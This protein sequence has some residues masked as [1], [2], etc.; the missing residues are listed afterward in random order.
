MNRKQ[1]LWA[2]LL[3][4]AVAIASCSSPDDEDAAPGPGP[5]DAELA[6]QVDVGPEGDGLEDLEDLEDPEVE[7]IE[8]EVLNANNLARVFIAANGNDSNAGNNAGSAVRSIDRAFSLVRPGGT[9]VFQAGTYPPLKIIG[10][11]GSSGAPIRLEASGSVEFRDSDYRSNAGIL[12][13]NSNH[14]EIV[15]MR[16]RHTLW[17]IYVENS[18]NMTIRGNDFGDIGQEG[19]R[20]KGGSSNIRID[21]NTVADTGRRTD[22]DWVNGEGCLLYTSDAADE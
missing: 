19:I 6:E 3:I 9:I 20:I 1:S 4:L 10:K 5:S 11:S 13:R 2:L 14:L 21:S 22:L 18:H 7:T 15:G 16:T 17:A 8:P 12:V